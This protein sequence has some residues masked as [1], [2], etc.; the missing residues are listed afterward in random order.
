[1]AKRISKTPSF[2]SA[3]QLLSEFK[4]K[5]KGMNIKINSKVTS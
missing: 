5:I 2:R 3:K 4:I 1:M